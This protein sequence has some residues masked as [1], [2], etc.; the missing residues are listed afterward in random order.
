MIL[1]ALGA[2]LNRQAVAAVDVPDDFVNE[3]VV[4]GLNQPTG[5]ARLPDGRILVIEQKTGAIR[6]AF[7]DLG[8]VSNAVFTVPDLNIVTGERGLLGIAVDPEWPAVPYV[9]LIYTRTGNVMR[10]VRYE[11]WG[12]VN[13]AGSDSLQFVQPLYL[14]DD[15]PDLNGD[16][17][18]GRL[19]FSP[20]GCLFVSL[21]DDQDV[22]S[23][24][25]STVITGQLLRL[26]VRNLPVVG[27]GQVADPADMVPA[28]NPFPNSGPVAALTWAY[29]MRN[30]W[31]FHID[32]V[33]G[34][35]YLADVGQQ[36]FEEI[37]DVLPGD[38][39]GWP[40]REGYRLLTR[41]AC[42]EPGGS[43]ANN[44]KGPIALVPHPP[45]TAAI[46]MGLM[47]REQQNGTANWPADYQGFYGN[48]FYG[49]YY[50]GWL[51]R[52][53]RQG[54]VWNAGAAVPGQPNSED[55]G[56]G[57]HTA[58][59]FMM[60][61]DGSVLWLAQFD[62]TF[63]PGTGH[64]SRI[65]YA[66][67]VDVPQPG[68]RSRTLRAAPNPFR[69]ATEISFTLPA[70]GNVR[71]EVFDVSGRRLRTLTDRTASPGTHRHSW[72][73]RDDAGAMTPPGVYL[74]RLVRDGR[75]ETL[76]VMRLR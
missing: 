64:I 40:W 72:D 63:T 12:A 66:P 62:D 36:Y 22:C 73:G 60:D 51:R 5:M 45:A 31:N 50:S 17:N 19:R 1:L 56:T 71:L 61:R 33:L 13:E 34:G 28:G 8:T 76:R 70:E 7:P 30:P 54:G 4:S 25:D 6:V 53:R 41:P 29:G 52:I 21:G 11:V 44:Y 26:E 3:T 46:F 14:F 42:P 23:A 16:H 49:E 32:P 55:W 58:T 27:M 10:L 67:L 68:V 69:A 74:A 75:A 47:Y 65:R 35:I 59:D 39:L 20:D 48:V 43:G 18:G 24:A 57:F 37:N 15:L 38:F 9:Y 2:G